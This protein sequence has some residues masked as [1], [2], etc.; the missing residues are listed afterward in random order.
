MSYWIATEQDE[1]L[2]YGDVY[3]MDCPYCNKTNIERI[4]KCRMPWD[5]DDEL[6]IECPNCKKNFEIRPK[7]KFE[8]FFIYTDDEQME[9]TSD[10]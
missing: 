1:V 3:I 7:Y 9:Q 4:N 6:R 5:K 8:G 2:D 10:R